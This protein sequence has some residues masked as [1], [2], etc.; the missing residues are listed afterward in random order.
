MEKKRVL[1]LDVVRYKGLCTV[2]DKSWGEVGNAALWTDK[3]H[4]TC[5]YPA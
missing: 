1:G 4:Y 5:I 3:M 2:T